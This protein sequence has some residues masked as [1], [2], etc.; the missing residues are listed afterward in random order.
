MSHVF[1]ILEFYEQTVKGSGLSENKFENGGYTDAE[2]NCNS[3][4]MGPC[5]QCKEDLLPDVPDIVP[6]WKSIPERFLWPAI[7]EDG[8][9]WAYKHKPTDM[10][11]GV[12]NGN[13]CWKTGRKFDMTS[14]DWTKTLSERPK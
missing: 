6:E 1:A 14:I 13:V 10:S 12:W 9:E 11:Y 5:G 4:C 7:D 2:I 3:G 8:T